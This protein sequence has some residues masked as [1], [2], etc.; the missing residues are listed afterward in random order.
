VRPKTIFATHYHELT[1][2][3]DALPSV[4]NCHV[5]AREYRDDIVFL[6]K[7]VP[8]R[9]DRSYGI[10]V[11]QIAGLPPAVVR[12]AAEILKALEQDELRRG[13]RPSL[14]GAPAAAQQQ[15]GLFQPATETHAVVERLRQLALDHLTPLDALNLLA[16]LKR[17]ADQ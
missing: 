15:L 14:S 16:D 2:L 6:H 13:G 1:D 4:V 12:R 3:A 10:H 5:A 9:S 7:I 11:A 8:G 17:E